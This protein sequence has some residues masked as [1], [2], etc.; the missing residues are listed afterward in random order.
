MSQVDL[1]CE[2]CGASFKRRKAE[3]TRNLKKGRRV[4]CSRSCGISVGNAMREPADIYRRPRKQQSPFNY[5]LKV[6]RRRNKD[7]T[8]TRSQLKAQWDT[9]QGRCP[10]TGWSM[11]LPKNVSAFEDAW[12]PENASVDRI[13]S[14]R[15]YEAGNIRFVCL[16]VNIARSKWSD[17]HL[18]KLA[19]A[20]LAQHGD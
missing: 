15:G 2:R 13:D 9:Q 14:S 7:C 17:D 20:I 12:H 8:L 11:R 19:K 16:S 5:F 1:V 10:V 4:F 18:I 3:H 6:I